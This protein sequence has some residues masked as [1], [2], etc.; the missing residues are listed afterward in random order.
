MFSG[1]RMLS[2]TECEATST[3]AASSDAVAVGTRQ[4]PLGDDALEAARDAQAV[5]VHVAAHQREHAA[6]GA[7]ASVVCSVAMHEVPRLGRLE[8]DLHRLL[9]ADLADEDDVGV[10]AQRRA[11]GRREARRVDAPPRAG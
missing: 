6:H 4:E 11:Q 3:S 9:V 2:F 1:R 10:L 5:L 8:G 7:H